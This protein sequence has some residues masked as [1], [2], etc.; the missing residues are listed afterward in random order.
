[1]TLFIAFT[2]ITGIV[3]P[4]VVTGISQIFFPYQA[5]G[6]LIERDGQIIGSDLIAQSF[7]NPEYFWARPSAVNYDAAAS[8]GSNLGPGSDVLLSDIES[9]SKLLEADASNLIPVDLVTASAS[10]LDP[11]ITPA[12][13]YYQAA[14]VAVARG[15]PIE[16]V[17]QLIATHIEAPTFGILG[18]A[19]VNVLGLNLALDAMEQ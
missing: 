14:R 12:S 2:L 4:L 9:R 5:N 18:E 13:A 8:G 17:E 16:T 6:S 3:Y 10:G 11:H 15:I 1:M 19:R 7:S